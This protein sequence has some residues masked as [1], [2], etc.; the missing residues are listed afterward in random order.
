MGEERAEYW[1][2]LTLFVLIFV[3]GRKRIDLIAA[4]MYAVLAQDRDYC[5]Y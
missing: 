1:K 3:G 5:D 4:K 2:L